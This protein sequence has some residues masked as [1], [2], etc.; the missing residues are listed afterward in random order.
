MILNRIRTLFLVLGLM[1]PL[2]VMFNQAEKSTGIIAAISPVDPIT[3][4]TTVTITGTASGGAIRSGTSR[5][6]DRTVHT[7]SM[8]AD[9]NGKYTDGPFFLQ[10]LGTFHD[11][12]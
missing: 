3:R 5:L 10:Q 4:E 2:A 7:S 8:K 6:H 12:L 9:S 11:V 1:L